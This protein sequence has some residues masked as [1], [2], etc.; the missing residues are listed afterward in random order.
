M[1]RL[2]RL[3]KI[4]LGGA[5]L[6][7]ATVGQAD[8]PPPFRHCREVINVPL[9][10]RAKVFDRLLT[11][12]PT[13][14]RVFRELRYEDKLPA[15]G[16][17][18]RLDLLRYALDHSRQLSYFLAIPDEMGETRD[19]RRAVVRHNLDVLHQRLKWI[20]E[21][22]VKRP[23]AIAEAQ[24]FDRVGD[25]FLGD[26]NGLAFRMGRQV[27]L[28]THARLLYQIPGSHFGTDH[29]PYVFAHSPA[30]KSVAVRA[31]P[32]PT[33]PTLSVPSSLPKIRA[34]PEAVHNFLG[35]LYHVTPEGQRNLGENVKLLV[36]FNDV[37]EVMVH[38]MGQ[39]HARLSAGIEDF[40][41]EPKVYL[42]FL[43]HLRLFHYHVQQSV[44][45]SPGRDAVLER[46]RTFYN[47]LTEDLIYPRVAKDVLHADF[48][49]EFTEFYRHARAH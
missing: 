43:R 26:W 33:P 36:A 3:W 27:L 35:Y 44:E 11:Q 34:V 30:V 46:I 25:F 10:L 19:Q 40:V 24:W 45:E 48:R 5:F 18:A 8:E 23:P 4:K 6:I 41:A 21:Y 22:S 17:E 29:S 38:G 32:V 9:N 37:T 2:K 47:T 7:V 20:E 42:E 31:K 15:E 14:E 39:A 13:F 12:H 1:K 49:E 28:D 16:L